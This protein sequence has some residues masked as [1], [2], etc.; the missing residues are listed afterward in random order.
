MAVY[1]EALT[2]AT[3]GHRGTTRRFSNTKFSTGTA[4]VK[5]VCIHGGSRV[6]VLNLVF[7]VY[8]SK[9]KFSTFEFLRYRQY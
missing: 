2:A 1:A 5:L 3:H 8:A 6:P 4:V 7:T 9:S